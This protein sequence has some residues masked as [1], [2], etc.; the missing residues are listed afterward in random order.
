MCDMLYLLFLSKIKEV[1]YIILNCKVIGKHKLSQTF[2]LSLR[3]VEF[4][5]N[6][7]FFLWVST[8]YGTFQQTGSEY[9]LKGKIIKK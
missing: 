7:S 5:D 6:I 2:L 9:N 8:K 3:L 1:N 4:F